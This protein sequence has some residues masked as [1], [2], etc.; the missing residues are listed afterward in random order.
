MRTLYGPIDSWRFGRSLGLDPLAARHKLCPFAC[1]YCQYGETRQRSLRR[2][3]FVPA[4]RLLSDIDQLPPTE[5]DCVTFAG[6]GEPTLARNLPSLLAAVRSRFSQP[7]ILLTGGALLPNHA[8]QSDLMD[9]DQIVITI[10]APNESLFRQ[11][12][13]PAPHY[14]YSWSAVID[15]IHR[16][17]QTYGGTLTLQVMLVQA[18]RDHVQEIA[19]LARSLAPAEIY[20]NTPLQPA[21]GGPLSRQQM[22]AAA[23][24]FDGLL[25]RSVY[26]GPTGTPKP[27]MD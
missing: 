26:G 8:V 5:L 13:R 23:S 10:N 14:P 22:Q 24:S 15:A 21:I 7:A 19:A 2:K 4:E 6:L 3:L 18:N 20:L 11:I 9:F 16:F 25:V 12:N 27:R 17:S 1:L